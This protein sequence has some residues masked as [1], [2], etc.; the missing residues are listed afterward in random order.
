MSTTVTYK[1]S[2]LT[3]V[4]NQTRV[5]NTAGKWL[6]GDI[7]LTDVTQGGSGT[8]AISIVDTAD[9]H[10]GTVREITALDISDTTAVASD[11]AQGKY[12]Y[13]ALGVKT[14]GTAS[15]GG[16]TPSQT[17]HTIYFE[18]EDNTNTTITG[19]WDGT[20]ISDAIRATTPRTY[21][22]KTVTLA[23]LDGT[24]WYSYNPSAIP[25]NTQLIDYS[26]CVANKALEQDGSVI[27]QEWYYA[28]D[29]TMVDH[30]MTFSYIAGTWTYIAFY[31]SS[32]TFISSIY[33]YNDGTVDP[34]DGN[35]A[36]GTLTP[37]KIPSNA[38]Y[39]RMSSVGDDD[40]NLSLIRT[41]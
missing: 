2:T 1:G 26:A 9:S 18:F 3:T 15:G 11:V 27:E 24:T 21:N 31:D 29:Y 17:Q 19:Y 40:E 7:T 20:F 12:F 33:V 37:S 35:L 13:T 41:A 28:T 14:T 22:N 4:N 25:L 34:D 10:G 30:S 6:E 32:K 39:V 16:G 5:L 36:T 38:K 23:Q 8:P